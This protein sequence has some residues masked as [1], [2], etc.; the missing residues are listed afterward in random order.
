MG[1]APIIHLGLL[2]PMTESADKGKELSHGDKTLRGI[3]HIGSAQIFTQL[4]N[5]GL[6]AVT[7]H[8]LDPRDYGLI[9]TAGI[10]TSLAQ[11][12]LDGGLADVL[13]S[14]RDL[15]NRVQGAAVS[16]VLL[17]SSLLAV[18]VIV[19]AP[20][21]SV[22]FHSPPLKLILDVSAFYLPLAGLD[23][24]PL[25]VLSKHMR[26]DRI[27]LARTVSSVVQGIATL[28]L[29]Y[30]GEGYWALIFGNFIG[31]ALRVI[32]LWTS[33]E[34]RP[35][36][37]LNLRALQHL[38]RNSGHMIGQ[39]LTF[40]SID[41]FDIFL[42]SRIG[43][44]VVLGPYSVARNLSHSPLSQIASVVNRVAVPAFAAKAEN[45][46]QVSG[47]LFLAS[48]AAT[49]LFPLFWIMGV[50]SQIALPLI[51]G[52][53]WSHVVVPFMA[54]SA[55]LPLRGLNT[56]LNS[57][58]IGTGRTGTTFR[59]TLSFA[60][61]AMPLMALGVV[62]G[63]DGVALSW[64]VSFPIVFYVGIRRIAADFSVQL[65]TFLRPIV[66]PVACAAASALAAELPL[67]LFRQLTPPAALLA[68][69]C[70]I[71]GLCYW[72]LLRYF[73]RDHYAQMLSITRRLIRGTA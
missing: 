6:T 12:L 18:A 72:S 44:P 65:A 24:V 59:N 53:R 56:L 10:I 38:L 20:I 54:F 9:A 62:K 40:F 71:G 55:V 42:L 52:V 60:A 70:G 7:I 17:V 26:F 32:L 14:Q 8:L 4:I 41:N 22:F 13:V 63:A 39:R 2:V 25:S 47:L 19:T 34:A 69:Q 5:W 3:R 31:T 33:L 50:A 57:A 51:F 30:L 45:A 73:G 58:V 68:I 64:I 46:A 28:G 43:G 16:A 15:P 66:R 21:G 27:A 35:I 29:A 67:L 11:L 1:A 61:I 23:V 49:V 48:I 36:P 37:N